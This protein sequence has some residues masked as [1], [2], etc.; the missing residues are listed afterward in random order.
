MEDWGPALERL[1]NEGWSLRDDV[2]VIVMTVFTSCKNSPEPKQWTLQVVRD[3][4]KA[5]YAEGNKAEMT[6][7]QNVERLILDFDLR[8]VGEGVGGLYT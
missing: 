3:S 5:A 6:V 4:L 7:K 8:K 2:S 1:R